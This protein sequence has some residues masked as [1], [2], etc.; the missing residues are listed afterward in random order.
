M[1]SRSELPVVAIV[2]GD[3]DLRVGG[4]VE[5]AL[6]ARVFA[7][8]VGDRAGGD[9]VVDLGPGLAAVV[10]APEVRVHVVEAQ[11]IG[12]G[13][14]GLGVEVA[15]IHIEDAGPGLD[16]RRRDVGPFRAA[17]GSDLDEAIAG[18]GPEHVDI[19]RRGRERGDGAQR[20]GRNRGCVLAGVGGDVPGLAGQIAADGGPAMAAVGGLPDAVAW[21]RRARSGLWATRSAAACERCARAAASSRSAAASATS[22]AAS[23]SGADAGPSG[24][25]RGYRRVTLPP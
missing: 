21:R 24:R 3:P 1:L 16:L 4:G 14:G 18:A 8:G 17:V 19:E 23:C 5:Q 13:I 9:A 6:L 22:S 20:R 7:D 25:S 12:G 2:E 11:G 10:R 15:G